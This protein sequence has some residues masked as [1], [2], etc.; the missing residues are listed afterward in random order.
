[1]NIIKRLYVYLNYKFNDK[2]NNK[3]ITNKNNKLIDE[4]SF[5]IKE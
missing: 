3:I 5:G 2:S 1:M 4:Y